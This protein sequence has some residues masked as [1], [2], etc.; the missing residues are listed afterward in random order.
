MLR[1]YATSRF[2]AWQ[3]V[4]CSWQVVLCSWQLQAVGAKLHC[5]CL[6]EGKCY[7]CIRMGITILKI[8]IWGGIPSDMRSEVT[9]LA[10]LT[11][12]QRTKFSFHMSNDNHPKWEFWIQWSPQCFCFNY[13]LSFKFLRNTQIEKLGL[14]FVL[15]LFLTFL[16]MCLYLALLFLLN[17]GC[18]FM[19]FVTMVVSSTWESKT[20]LS[21]LMC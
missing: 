14:V 4:L 20:Y 11:C 17:L 13:Y 3:V 21:H 2:N 9:F 19:H 18:L 10:S 1:H 16:E 15:T 7:F 8:I 6:F 5:H 12:H